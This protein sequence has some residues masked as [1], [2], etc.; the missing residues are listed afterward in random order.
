MAP[1]QFEYHYHAI[2]YILIV[3]DDQC[4]DFSRRHACVVREAGDHM[5]GPGM[6]TR[7]V[8]RLHGK[9]VST[10]RT[11]RWQSARPIRIFYRYGP[12]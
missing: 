1:H 2:A 4:T 5:I 6:Q 12:E 7:A 11:G 9:C 8:H 3:I 10:W